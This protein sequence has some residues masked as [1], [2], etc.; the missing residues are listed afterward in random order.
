MD[1]TDF[2]GSTYSYSQ[3]LTGGAGSQ[4][5][6]A[7]A[8]KVYPGDKV[9]IEAYGKYY[10]PTG[11]TSNITGFATALTSAFGVSSTSTGEALSVYNTLNNYGG[12]IAAGGPDGTDSDHPKL[13]VTILLFDKDHN[14]L[15]A[16]WDQIDGGEQ[17][18]VSPKAAHDYM[19]QEVTVT[20][21]GYAYVYVSN[22]NPTLVEFYVDDVTITHTPTNV[23]QYN[24]YY[25]FGL[26]TSSSW[27]RENSKG[28]QFL[29]NAANE[30]NATSGWYEM[31]YR[32]YDPAIGRMLQVDPYATN[33]ASFTTYN[34]AVN[35]P[36]MLNDPSGG[37]SVSYNADGISDVAQQ[38]MFKLSYYHGVGG[39]A[40][41]ESYNVM[42]GGGQ[43]FTAEYLAQALRDALYNY[44]YNN[45][46]VSID[47]SLFGTVL[48]AAFRGELSINGMFMT[49][50]YEN[51]IVPGEMPADERAK[52][53]IASW[54]EG[55]GIAESPIRISI[56]SIIDRNQAR[57]ETQ[58]EG[59][60]NSSGWGLDFY[61]IVPV[62]S[63]PMVEE[64]AAFTPGPVIVKSPTISLDK[65]NVRDRDLIRHEVGHVAT[66]AV[67]GPVLYIATIAIPSVFSFNN[68]PANHP[69]YYTEK[70]ANTF[71]EWI[72]GPFN[73]PNRYPSY[74]RK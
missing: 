21:P 58:G 41:A 5:G 71:S 73:D 24:E 18:G 15:D 51:K 40:W 14:F 13:F 7:K 20:E 38:R 39:S 65:S 25:P 44:K 74:N 33:Y 67:I 45:G 19:S 3:K 31:F 70:I 48:D 10:N 72:Y 34:Y 23:I 62:I 52:Y 66:F 59:S 46:P 37:Y 61:G 54:V 60:N 42:E 56:Q 4:V 1:H 55:G 6:V 36:V 32:G 11:T 50:G 68:D 28:N 22:E 16:A 29:Y 57:R 69:S 26:Q 63:S 53:N 30:L 47:R 43:V 35:N 12:F 17:I 49:V 64:D 2:S 9:K 8:M 27:T